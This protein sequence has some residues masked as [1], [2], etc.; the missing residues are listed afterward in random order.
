MNEVFHAQFPGEII[1]LARVLPP[2]SG[3][4]LPQLPPIPWTDNHGSLANR[5]FGALFGSNYTLQTQVVWPDSTPQ[6][7]GAE[8]TPTA[9]LA[10]PT[11]TLAFPD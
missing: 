4:E 11:T 9:P 1:P 8:S 5:L 2:G 3:L 7:R 10:S 6:G